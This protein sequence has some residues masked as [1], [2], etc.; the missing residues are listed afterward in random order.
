MDAFQRSSAGT[1][2]RALALNDFAWT[3]AVWGLDIA[4]AN[5]VKPGQAVSSD[6]CA[7]T[8]MPSDAER[9]AEQ[10]VCIV[11]K[12]NQRRDNRGKYAAL[13]SNLRETL[14]YVR[15]QNNEIP[16]AL[17]TYA[18]IG[19]DD[20]KSL[21]DAEIS[22]RYAIARYAGGQDKAAALA[23]FKTAVVDGQYQPTH[24][25][26]TL[27]DYIFPVEDFVDILRTSTNELWPPLP[28]RTN[29][30]CPAHQ[31]GE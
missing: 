26:Q 17:E 13:L 28:P 21:K 29:W 3:E 27:R 30:A 18:D 24:E 4:D 23:S 14:A 19:R 15:L 16:Q 2:E 9:A 6:P 8:D 7:A 12:L 25:L 11:D 31:P 10:A 5:T 20:P 22:F 1:V